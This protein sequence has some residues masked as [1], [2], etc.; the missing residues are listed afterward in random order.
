MIKIDDGGE[1]ELFSYDDINI[2]FGL[3]ILRKV[4]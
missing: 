2:R 3:L 4:F 1:V